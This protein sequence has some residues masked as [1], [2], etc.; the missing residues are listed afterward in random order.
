V[1]AALAAAVEESELLLELSELE[2]P[3]PDSAGLLSEDDLPESLP[4]FAAGSFSTGGLGR[5]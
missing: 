5:P 1:L 3:A 4:F 2:E